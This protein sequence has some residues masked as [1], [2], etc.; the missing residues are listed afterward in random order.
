M[1]RVFRQITPDQQSCA[2]LHRSQTQ[3]F[4]LAILPM[5]LAATND[6]TRATSNSD[7]ISIA[8]N[9]DL[10]IPSHFDAFDALGRAVGTKRSLKEQIRDAKA[11]IDLPLDPKLYPKIQGPDKRFYH[12]RAHFQQKAGPS[13]VNVHGTLLLRLTESDS[14]ST[15]GKFWACHECYHI[16][17]AEATTSP[18][19]HLRQKHG[20]T[21]DGKSLR[22]NTAGKRSLPAI[23]ELFQ[24][25][26]TK[27]TKLPPPAK[28]QDRFQ[29]LL[30]KWVSDSDIPF[31]RG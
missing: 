22:A 19:K 11:I 15:D 23:D 21:K 29:E 20:I 28:T 26:T 6:T 8:P 5:T 27:K 10:E 30:V 16:F 18:A 25:R 1:G 9:I 2:A 12:L 3:L 13:W 17:D 31:S 24:A 7:N 4:L 14:S